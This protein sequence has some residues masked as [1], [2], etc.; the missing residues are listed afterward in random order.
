MKASELTEM[1]MAVLCKTMFPLSTKRLQQ[2]LKACGISPSG[3][4]RVVAR[5]EKAGML[6]MQFQITAKG[7][8]TLKAA[9]RILSQQVGL[10]IK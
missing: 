8:R 6:E 4:G 3:M 1:E 2:S 5:L 7:K 9:K 10:T